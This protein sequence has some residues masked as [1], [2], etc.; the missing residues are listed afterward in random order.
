[1]FEDVSGL[2][3]WHRRWIVLAGNKLCFWKYPDD[4]NKKVMWCSILLDLSNTHTR[5]FL[6]KMWELHVMVSSMTRAVVIL[7]LTQGF[8]E[9]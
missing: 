2:G 8:A 3:A 4:E 9:D 6:P 1:M 5:V 7:K